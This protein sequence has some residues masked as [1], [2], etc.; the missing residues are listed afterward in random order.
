[1]VATDLQVIVLNPVQK[2]NHICKYWGAD[3][4]EDA[5]KHAEALV[6]HHYCEYNQPHWS[7][8]ILYSTRSD[9]WNLTVLSPQSRSSLLRT[10]WHTARFVTLGPGGDKHK[11]NWTIVHPK[12]LP[13]GIQ[14]SRQTPGFRGFC[15]SIDSIVWRRLREFQDKGFNDLGIFEVVSSRSKLERK[16]RKYDSLY[17]KRKTCTDQVV[18]L[19]DCCHFTNGNCRQ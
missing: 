6:R 7:L 4:Y 18:L 17:R 14:A 11:L 10:Q 19:A 3:V 12:G 13:L 1:M 2:A 15:G 9:T 5:M 8:R 16:Y